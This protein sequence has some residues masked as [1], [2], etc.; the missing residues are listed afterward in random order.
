MS[1]L[2]ALK[3]VCKEPAVLESLREVLG[4]KTAGFVSSIISAASSNP[5]LMACEPLSIVRAAAVAAALDLPINQNLGLAWLVPY[6][7]V[8]T[9]QMGWKGYVELAQRTGQY[10]RMNATPVLEGQIKS[11]N[12]FTG[13][14]VFQEEATSQKVQ[15][16]LFYFRLLTGFEKFNYWTADEMLAHAK[17][18]SKSFQ[19]GGGVWAE[20]FE[21]MALKTV[22][23][24]SLGKWGPKSIEVAKAANFDGGHVLDIASGAVRFPDNEVT[25]ES[26][27]EKLAEIEAARAALIPNLNPPQTCEQF[28]AATKNNPELL[29]AM[30]SGLESAGHKSHADKLVELMKADKATGEK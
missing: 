12:S 4:Q 9:F 27:V 19:K 20:N 15:G 16:Y 8:C 29:E 3:T 13:D 22:T 14:F 11:R 28:Y 21:A 23:K 25:H 18:Y 2:V 26:S 1:N 6:K 5:S 10:A 30:I 7:G 17:R 24:H